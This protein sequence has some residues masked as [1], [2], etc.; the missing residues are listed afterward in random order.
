MNVSGWLRRVS[1]SR[2]IISLP[3][4]QLRRLVLLFGNNAFDVASDVVDLRPLGV[5]DALGHFLLEVLVRVNIRPLTAIAI[6]AVHKNSRGTE[7][8]LSALTVSLQGVE[9]RDLGDGGRHHL[10]A[11]S[12]VVYFHFVHELLERQVL[13]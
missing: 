12:N 6:Q 9:G 11:S 4:R 3:G 13:I 8:N 10:F 2:A 5:S 7:A 1:H